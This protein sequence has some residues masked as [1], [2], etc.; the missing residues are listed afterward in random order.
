[1]V[2]D[3]KKWRIG[4]YDRRIKNWMEVQRKERIY[5]LG[6][7]PPLMLVFAGDVHGVDHGRNQHGLGGG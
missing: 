2:L 4:D 1:M 5:D 3:L 6:S 7:L